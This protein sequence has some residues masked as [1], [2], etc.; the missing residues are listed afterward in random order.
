MS[1]EDQ[2]IHLLAAGIDESKGETIQFN[3]DGAIGLILDATS[4]NNPAS[5]HE[6]D[7]AKMCK[8]DAL[9]GDNY[10]WLIV[11]ER[12]ICL[13]LMKMAAA[14]VET[15]AREESGPPNQPIFPAQRTANVL[16]LPP[17]ED[18]AQSQSPDVP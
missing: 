7:V 9:Q 14:Y 5:K 17:A 8:I 16:R 2:I 3:N 10:S 15:Q 12:I 18:G 11:D 4:L 6:F 13:T 1:T